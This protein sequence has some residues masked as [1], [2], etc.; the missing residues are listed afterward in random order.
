MTTKHS[1]RSVLK[2]QA[3][4]IAEL[5]KRVERGE[6]ISGQT[7]EHLAAARNK[8]IVQIGIVM[9]DKTIKLDIPWTTVRETSE[10][11]LT[12]YILN[13]MMELRNVIN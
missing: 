4:K 1:P 9:D 2:A 12:E 8:E 6:P 5:I 11:G 7:A 10:L 3:E 13:Q